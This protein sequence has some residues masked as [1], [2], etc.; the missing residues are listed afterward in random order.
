MKKPSEI[1]DTPEATG[2]DRVNTKDIEESEVGT[3]KDY[4]HQIITAFKH[5]EH[6]VSHFHDQPVMEAGEEDMMYDI[7]IN[8]LTQHHQAEVERA[9]EKTNQKWLLAIDEEIDGMNAQGSVFEEMTERITKIA[10]TQPKQI[11]NNTM[12]TKNIEE[13]F[14]QK[15]SEGKNNE[16][17]R[18]TDEYEPTHVQVDPMDVANWLRTTLTTL[19]QHHQAEVERAYERGVADGAEKPLLAIENVRE[20][21]REKFERAIGK[22]IMKFGH[23]REELKYLIEALTPTKTD[24]QKHYD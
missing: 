8:A 4:A 7:I 9:V 19:T 11:S 10:L 17:W 13:E 3:A 21:E 24:K 18:I 1:W 20:A 23:G 14:F 2:F 6:G 22:T 16:C 15:F 5:L 12:S